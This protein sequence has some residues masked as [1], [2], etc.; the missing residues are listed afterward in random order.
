M[1]LGAT[2]R[3]KVLVSRAV[4]PNY[5]AVLRTYCDGLDVVVDELPF[6]ED[7]VTDFDALANGGR[8]RRVRGRRAAVAELLR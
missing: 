1:A 7:G 8:R 5:R 3:H 2:G 4:H 6:T